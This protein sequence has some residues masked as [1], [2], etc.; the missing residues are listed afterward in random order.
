MCNH[1]SYN[2]CIR[3]EPGFCCTEYTVCND[4]TNTYN[5]GNAATTAEVG[6]SCIEDYV[7]IEGAGGSKNSIVGPNRFCGTNLN[8]DGTAT[9][10]IPI[11]GKHK[12]HITIFFSKT[13]KNSILKSL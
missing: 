1:C 11:I 3:Q 5:F 12:L 6:A 13:P 2:A 4:D 8:F 7:Y 9:S 10:N